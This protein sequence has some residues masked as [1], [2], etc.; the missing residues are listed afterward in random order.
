MGS[1]ILALG[2]KATHCVDVIPDVAFDFTTGRTVSVNG[3]M[4]SCG[5]TTP[6]LQFGPGGKLEAI[7]ANVPRFKR[8]PESGQ[9]L[10][11]LIEP[12]ATNM[13]DHNTDLKNAA[14]VKN[15]ATIDNSTVDGLSER[16]MFKLNET[17]I[18]SYH[19]L[20]TQLKPVSIE[21][22]LSASLYVKA[23]ERQ[24]AGF[25]IGF[26]PESKSLKAVVNLADGSYT[27]SGPLSG[28]L[29]VK[30]CID[31]IYLLQLTAKS[32]AVDF[33]G[34]TG[35]AS[36][37]AHDG[38]SATYAGVPGNGIYIELP[39]LEASARPTSTIQTYD[40]PLTRGADDISI[41]PRSLGDHLNP[42][43]FTIYAE[44]VPTLTESHP[45][46]AGEV[47][48]AAIALRNSKD[49]TSTGVKCLLG[50]LSETLVPYMFSRGSQ[51]LRVSGKTAWKSGK[52]KL[53]ANSNG[54]FAY[55]GVLAV[56][57]GFTIEPGD[58]IQIGSSRSGKEYFEGYIVSI[59]LYRRAL[60]D[61]KMK[62][63][64]Q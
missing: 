26:K 40:T 17:D 25:E 22:Y 15:N 31:G 2:V 64:T 42:Q 39:Q 13:L 58:T 32:S 60:P 16:K 57:D 1:G 45:Y 20:D 51:Y 10:G 7:P 62:L 24:H 50:R 61:L 38:Q 44:A 47:S 55:G 30:K 52:M 5:R 11:L 21:G 6:A 36:M 8:D 41:D 35:R 4:L 48:P 56:V 23:G 27:L 49:V 63:I 53:A 54:T 37:L 33:T 29:T 3:V 19:S 12:E 18:N 28:Y 46:T 59:R 14:Y 43:D 9:I 34:V